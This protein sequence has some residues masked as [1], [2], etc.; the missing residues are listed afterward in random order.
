MKIVCVGGGPA[1]LY[2]AILMKRR[3][4]GHDVTVYERNPLDVTHGFGVTFWDELLSALFI[5]DPTSAA[6]IKAAAFDWRGQEV[7]VDGRSP[8]PSDGTGYG[9]D[10]HVLIHILTQRA[11]E[12]GVTLRFGHEVDPEDVVA[13]ADLVVAAD[14]VR[15]RVR[16]QHAAELEPEVT[17]GRN[18]YVWLG[19][20]RVFRAF[21]YAFA[22][23]DAGWLWCYAYGY[24]DERSTFI[25]ECSPE[26]WRGL[27][28]DTLGL[29]DSLDL[30]QG[31]FARQLDGHPLMVQSREAQ[32]PWVNWTLIR[33]S[34]WHTGNVALMGDA[35]HTTHFSI[36]SGTRL[37]LE[38]AIALASAL[39]RT[40]D[41]ATALQSYE[42]ERRSAILPAQRDAHYSSKWFENVPRYLPLDT[43]KFAA[44][45]HRRRS[46][47]LAVVPPKVFLALRW[48]LDQSPVVRRVWDRAQSLRLAQQQSRAR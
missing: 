23:T 21:T 14:G 17:L 11:A 35:A 27:H 5:N 37:A 9:I 22:E 29:Q 41:V 39:D 42:S 25:V 31:L 15:S 28:L 26:T 30:L 38:D 2:F 19:T 45:L 3:D 46:P 48:P 43:E 34:T 24:S 6:E 44:I 33:M 20:P 32:M 12:L 13:G 7:D 36:G 40:S 4:P 10:R 8:V 47:I 18:K 16:A 1:G